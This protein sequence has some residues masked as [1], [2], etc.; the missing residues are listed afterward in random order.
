MRSLTVICISVLLVEMMINYGQVKHV[1]HSNSSNVQS[2]DTMHVELNF[3]FVEDIKL[4]NTQARDRKRRKAI[5][6][7]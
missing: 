6:A 2:N 5:A 1:L 7:I 3:T 4:R